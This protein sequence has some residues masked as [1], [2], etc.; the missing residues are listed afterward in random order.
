[1]AAWPSI[2]PQGLLRGL[3]WKPRDIVL[4]SQMDVGPDKTR[5][6]STFTIT[7]VT[8]RLSLTEAQALALKNFYFDT[9]RHGTERFSLNSPLGNEPMEAKFL[10]PPESTWVGGNRWEATLK[11][12]LFDTATVL[13]NAIWPDGENMVWPDG[14]NALWPD[15]PSN[16][17]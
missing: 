17:G 4:R 14:N 9:T 6:R 11:L 16:W 10:E 2:L 8:G 7:D 3:I 13:H 15:L 5:L 1:M 12:E